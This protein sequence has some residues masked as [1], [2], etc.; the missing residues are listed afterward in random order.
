MGWCNNQA[1]ENN[2]KLS[3]P[4]LIVSTKREKSFTVIQEEVIGEN[5]PDVTILINNIL[6]PRM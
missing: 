5:V 3:Y 1:F 6:I 4:R 2:F